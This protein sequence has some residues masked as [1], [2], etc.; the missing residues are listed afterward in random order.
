MTPRL[1]SL[2]KDQIKDSLMEKFSYKNKMEV[3]KLVKIVLNMGLGRLSDA[4]KDDKIIDESVEEL[5][6]IV[7]QKTV[8]TYA[9]TVAGKS[10][11]VF[12]LPGGRRL[13]R[14]WPRPLVCSSV[15]A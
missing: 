11:Y 3:P 6:L 7:G 4:G 15:F 10:P 5:G 1:K 8:V 2:Y 12:A 9:K 14:P 13:Q